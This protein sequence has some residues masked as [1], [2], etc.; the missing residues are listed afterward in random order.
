MAVAVLS[1]SAQPQGSNRGERQDP[2]KYAKEVSESMAKE[3][4]LTDKQ[5]EQIY[6][7]ELKVAKARPAAGMGQGRQNLSEDEMKK[8]R[9]DREKRMKEHQDGVKKVLNDEQYE[10]WSKL[11]QERM[12]NRGN[13]MRN[14]EVKMERQ[15]IKPA[16]KEATVCPVCSKEKCICDKNQKKADKKK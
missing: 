7:L 3:L 12:N 14:G 13:Q 10:K 9:E 2:E 8:F 11:R 5:K 15:E 6:D 4:S 1:V 16:T